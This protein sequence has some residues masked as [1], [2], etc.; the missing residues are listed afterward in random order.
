MVGREVLWT[1]ER[2]VPI[3]STK[4]ASMDGNCTIP[5]EE[6]CF[7][8]NT[9]VAPLADGKTENGWRRLQVAFGRNGKLRP[10]Y[11]LVGGEPIHFS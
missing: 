5:V 9:A 1:F 4:I 11:A 8:A 3:N 7:M 2:K 10:K 6:I